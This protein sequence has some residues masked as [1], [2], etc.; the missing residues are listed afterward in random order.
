M[1]PKNPLVSLVIP[2]H[3][4]AGNLEWLHGKIDSFFTGVKDTRHEIIF[5]DDGSG[6]DSL[7][8]IHKLASRDST[9]RYA[10][11][12]RNFGK[13]AA[14][15]AGIAQAEGDAIVIMDGDGQHPVELIATFITKWQ[16]GFDVVVGLRKQNKKEG[17]VKRYGSK[18]HYRILSSLTGGN[19]LPGATDFRLIDR[20]VADEFNKLTERSR[21]AR[22]LIDWLGFKRTYVEFVAPARHSGTAAYSFRK[23]VRLALHSFTSQSTK[24]L[25]FTG[26]LGFI[27]TIA[28]AILGLFLIV[29]SYVLGDPLDLAV[30]GTAMLALF[31]SFLV[32]LVLICQWLLA[33]YVESIHNETQNRPLYIIDKRSE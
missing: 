8:I 31:L 16:A 10:G 4:E 13:E 29:E 28:A 21:I 26:F 19:T 5:V 17:F 3:D 20:K 6:D 1:R 23:L 9:V 7:E 24:P 27:V 11:L 22:G 18:L 30:T 32:G 33:L 14:T 25:Q 12:S 15:S 2:V